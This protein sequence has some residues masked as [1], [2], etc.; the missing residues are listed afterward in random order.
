[1]NIAPELI[2]TVQDALECAEIM[3][4][5]EPDKARDDCFKLFTD[6][7][8]DIFVIKNSGKVVA[9]CVIETCGLPSKTRVVIGTDAS[10][11]NLE[12]AFTEWLGTKAQPVNETGVFAIADRDKMDI[13]FIYN[14][15]KTLYWA[16]NLTRENLIGRMMNSMCFGV[17]AN[18][19]QKGFARV[20]TDYFAFAYLAD[21]FVEEKERGK[22]YSRVLMEYIFNY[23]SLRD[24]KWLLATRDMHG[25][26]KKFGFTPVANPERFMGKNGWQSF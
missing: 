23:P 11:K 25:L 22:G 7:S 8:K 4:Q 10:H 14:N 21:V 5:I 16:T 18:G 2:V 17:F 24:I 9:Y 20:V 1:M 12:K 13:D 19:S 15:L 3:L 6:R 26:Y